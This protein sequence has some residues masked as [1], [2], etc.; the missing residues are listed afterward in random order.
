M[1]PQNDNVLLLQGDCL[2]LMRQI[3]DGSVDLV[4]CDP[5]YGMD[6]QSARRS[7]RSQWKPK[8]ANDKRPFVWFVFDAARTLKDGGALICFCRFD[9]WSAFSDACE[10]AGL[11]VKAEIVWDKMNHG[12]GDLKGCPGFRHEIAVFA[13]KGRFQF[14]GKRPQSLIAIPRVSPEKL[15]H[16]NEKPVQLMTWLVDH[17]CPPD[18]TVLDPFTG[19]SPVG[20]ACLETGRKFI[21]MEIDQ[22]YFEIARNRILSH[23]APVNDNAKN[24]TTSS[25]E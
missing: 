20:V 17:Y 21:G 2:E 3:P 19:V 7:D 5:P 18:G 14:H 8:I 24:Q 4:L 15:A 11:S 16:P 10:L 13:T 22:N 9:S 1:N 25:G 23:P 6:Y 12:T